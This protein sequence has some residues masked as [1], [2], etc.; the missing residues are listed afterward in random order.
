MKRIIS[1]LIVVT[2]IAS[3]IG[4]S[5][6]GVFASSYDSA[7]DISSDNNDENEKSSPVSM[8]PTT[9][10]DYTVINNGYSV[11]TSDELATMVGVDVLEKGGNAVDAAI[12]ISYALG[13]LE[14]YA[15]GI[16]GGGGMLIYDPEMDSY[17]FLN[18]FSTA[19]PSGA[20]ADS[21]SVPGFVSGLEKAYELY[22]TMDFSDLLSYAIE[23]AENGFEVSSEL[24]YRITDYNSY[25][26]GTP[27]S[28]VREGDT[29][30]QTELAQYLKEIDQDGANAFYSGSIASQIQKYTDLTSE[31]L[32][33]YETK[34]LQPVVSEV[35]GYT[36]ASAPAPFSGLT[37][38]QMMKM[39]ELLNVPDPD[40]DAQTYLSDFVS[41]KMTAGTIRI[42]TISDPNY[43]DTSLNYEELLSDDYLLQYLETAK[44]EYEEDEESIDTTH[45][46]VVDSNGMAV[47]VTNTL[48]QFWGSKVYAGGFFLGNN[49]ENF[50]NGINS[51][52]PGKQPRT[53][54]SPTI[55]TSEDGYVMAIGSPGG[56]VIP[57]VITTVLS[58]ILLYGTDPQ[59]AVDKQRVVVQSY[60]T[61]MVEAV[62]NVSPLVN[63]D[64]SSYYL[65]WN[66][67]RRKFGSVNIAGYD[68]ESGYFAT[69]D[70]RRSGFGYASNE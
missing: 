39:M 70:E 30:I 64:N 22:G 67:N 40:E 20:Q 10:D 14:P 38:I 63:I 69:S 53:F 66:D 19:A 13:V 51:Y 58:D 48:S 15:S 68:P 23:Y 44:S 52:E 17:F 45:I 49:L 8:V 59:E 11:S 16:G 5:L 31:D 55:V 65:V 61:L 4:Y 46:S 34:V 42:N 35:N 32:L 24:A 2:I 9:E 18:Y 43:S 29:L 25:M 12:A 1:I 37:V 26:Q 54:T 57:N 41:I 62:E 6:Q 33:S 28:D 27:F 3:T 60:D 50:S 21:I 56:N 47:S 36:I 7:E